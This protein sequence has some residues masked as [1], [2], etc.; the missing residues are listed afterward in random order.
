MFIVMK[1]RVTEWNCVDSLCVFNSFQRT[2]E[3]Q[4]HGIL[5]SG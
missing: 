1:G 4:R 5:L 3:E 2:I